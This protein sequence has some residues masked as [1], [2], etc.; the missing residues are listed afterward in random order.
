[1]SPLAYQYV[2]SSF[3]IKL[4]ICYYFLNSN[5]NIETLASFFVFCY[6]TSVFFA[7]FLL[8]NMYKYAILLDLFRR[9]KNSC[10]RNNM[11]L[12]NDNN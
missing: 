8:I 12:K 3:I 9:I 10:L 1:M 11:F 7:R 4:N 2:P 6:I 5:K